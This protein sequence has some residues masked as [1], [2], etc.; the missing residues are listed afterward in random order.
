[1]QRT[2][3]KT[4]QNVASTSAIAERAQQGRGRSRIGC[5]VH[6]VRREIRGMFHETNSRL[7]VSKRFMGEGEMLNA[8]WVNPGRPN[9]ASPLQLWISGDLPTPHLQTPH[10][11]FPDFRLLPHWQPVSA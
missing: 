1:M 11:S 2:T 4:L 10:L 3:S 6:F 5:S 8:E 9:R 7:G